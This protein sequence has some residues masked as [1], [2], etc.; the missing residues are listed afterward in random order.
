MNRR[1]SSDVIISQILEVC[2]EGASKTRIVY[3]SNLNF[4]T[5]NPYL[6]LLIAHGL[7]EM[8]NGR[9]TIYKTTKKGIELMKSFK[10]YQDE[11]SKLRTYIE[12]TVS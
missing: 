7:L 9:R 6:D 4:S 2:I 11:I 3:Q 5:V 10:H 12:N 1:R 8:V